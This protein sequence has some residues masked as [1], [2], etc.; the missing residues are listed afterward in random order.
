M[1]FL[2]PS[3]QDGLQAITRD[4]KVLNVRSITRLGKV[5][6]NDADVLKAGRRSQV[7]VGPHGEA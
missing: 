5:V 4:A 7:H 2:P 3:V 1:D 6:C